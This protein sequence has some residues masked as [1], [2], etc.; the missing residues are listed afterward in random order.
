[1]EALKV[2]SR[3]SVVAIPELHRAGKRGDPRRMGIQ[4]TRRPPPPRLALSPDDV[5]RFVNAFATRFCPRV[6]MFVTRLRL[7]A[8]E[9][10]RTTGDRCG[11]RACFPVRC[12]SIL[13]LD[14]ASISLGSLGANV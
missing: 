14:R 1:M 10:S 5:L 11:V 9:I 8:L 12:I 3:S 13:L 4:G 2:S 7:R 6:R